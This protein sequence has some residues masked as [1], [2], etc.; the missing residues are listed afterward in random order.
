MMALPQPGGDGSPGLGVLTGGR[1]KAWAAAWPA[2]VRYVG[3]DR[4]K[5]IVGAA[6]AVCLDDRELPESKCRSTLGRALLHGDPTIEPIRSHDRWY[7][8]RLQ[9]VAFASGDVGVVAEHSTT[10]GAP[11]A[12]ML[13]TIT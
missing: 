10:D 9:V 2:F 12:E 3:D 7:D 8:S 13:H 4:A 5:S 6:F 1:R 11:V